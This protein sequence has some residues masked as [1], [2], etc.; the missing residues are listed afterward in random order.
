MT[1]KSVGIDTSSLLHLLAG[2][3]NP[4][5]SVPG[6]WEDYVNVMMINEVQKRRKEMDQREDER[7]KH[8]D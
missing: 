1:V 6:S 5:G 2:Y 4:R 7:Q 3:W 8:F